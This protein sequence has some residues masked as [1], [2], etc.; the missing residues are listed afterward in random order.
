[1]QESKLAFS[2]AAVPT[3]HYEFARQST[4]AAEHTDLTEAP[5]T[6]ALGTNQRPASRRGRAPLEGGPKKERE[7]RWGQEGDVT[8]P[9]RRDEVGAI[10]YMV[11]LLLTPI[12]YGG[13]YYNLGG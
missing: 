5:L 12:L 3:D 11:K 4:G 9:A 7:K 6:E 13:L 1:M 8:C 10:Y 2:A